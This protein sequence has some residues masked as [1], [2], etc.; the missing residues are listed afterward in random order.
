MP[1]RSFVQNPKKALR[2]ITYSHRLAHTE[3]LFKELNILS[4][5]KLYVFS[6]QLFMIK[7][8]NAVLPA[9]FSDFF[10]VNGD[11]QD[12]NTRQRLQYHTPIVHSQQTSR[13]VRVTGVRA[14]HIFSSIIG[15][16]C[17][18]GQYKKSIKRHLIF[19]DV[20][21]KWPL[22]MLFGDLGAWGRCLGHAWVIASQ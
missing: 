15:Y 19:H 9:V 21:L 5:E 3:S 10:V 7:F 17:S 4:I 12:Y 18:I 14:H 8:S 13:R 1:H 20:C 2:L 11:V 22:M 6:V 16:S